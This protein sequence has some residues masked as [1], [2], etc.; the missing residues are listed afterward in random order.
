MAI[1]KTIRGCNGDETWEGTAV[2]WAKKL[3]CTTQKIWAAAK[4]RD[5]VSDWALRDMGAKKKGSKG[6]ASYPSLNEMCRLAKEQGK[7]YGQIQA[8]MYEEQVR[9]KRKKGLK[10]ARESKTGKEADR[11]NIKDLAGTVSGN[12]ET[13][14]ELRSSEDNSHLGTIPAGSKLWERIDTEGIDA[15]LFSVTENCGLCVYVAGI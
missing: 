8:E 15:E 14:L 11:L 2:E 6:K 3:N 13:R 4:K 9:A 1:K 10:S 12:T 5:K 7:S